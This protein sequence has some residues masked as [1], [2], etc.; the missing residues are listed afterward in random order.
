MALLAILAGLGWYGMGW[1]IQEFRYSLLGAKADDVLIG[2]PVGGLYWWLVTTFPG[3][4]YFRY[5]AKLLVI[6]SLGLSVL[7]ANGFDRLF[8]TKHEWLRRVVVGLS[9]VSLVAMLATYAITSPWTRWMD[10]APKDGL[11]G[12]ID[13]S[14]S[15]ADLRITFLHTAVLG[16]L[17][18]SLLSR[19]LNSNKIKIAPLLVLLTA[20]DLAIANGWMLPTAPIRRWQGGSY[21]A[22]Q[23]TEHEAERGNA[24]PFRVYRGTTR[25]WLPPSWAK[26]SSSERQREGLKWDIDTLYP[27]YHLRAGLSLVE[28]TGTMSSHDYQMFLGAARRHGPKRSDGVAE[29][30]PAVIGALGAK[31][32]LAPDDLLFPQMQ[33]ID[34]RDDQERPPKA[35]LLLNHDRLPRTWIVRDI[36]T[37]PQL[38]RADPAAIERR[39]NEALFPDGQPRD[40]RETAV[41]E[42]DALIVMPDEISNAASAHLNLAEVTCEIVVDEPHCV[43]VV[44]DVKRPGLLVLSDL[45]YPG[46]IAE[47]TSQP[48]G[49]PTRAP[50]LRTNR[51][52]R[53]VYLKPGKHRIVFAYRPKT[54][55][56]GAIVSAIGWIVLAGAAVYWI[57]KQSSSLPP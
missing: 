51:I 13:A 28:S 27:K 35:E 8:T 54:V 1:A 43:E 53:G 18:W 40:L 29:P 38:R 48:N 37:L 56:A 25:N 20:V 16:V 55:Y 23:I 52:M 9:C 2:Q 46:W 49:G 42:T 36:V 7:A 3:Y 45:Y 12:P 44:A 33:R 32:V 6:A 19:I 31:Y 14:G 41:V 17:I 39:T 11:F 47:V 30:H 26:T 34:R 4:A 21:F 10:A 57:T 24:E 15:L 50:I 5:P 22:K